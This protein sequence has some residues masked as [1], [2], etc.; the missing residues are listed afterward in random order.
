MIKVD[1]DILTSP[2][3]TRLLLLLLR[4]IFE[5]FKKREMMKTVSSNVGGYATPY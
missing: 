2:G 4:G 1:V 5:V 3:K